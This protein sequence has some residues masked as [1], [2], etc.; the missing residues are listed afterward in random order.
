MN[1]RS[2]AFPLIG[3]CTGGYSSDCVLKIMRDE[4]EKQAFD[5]Q[6]RIVRFKE[7]R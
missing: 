4:A 5:G 2:I 3:A 7:S 6:I 1:Y